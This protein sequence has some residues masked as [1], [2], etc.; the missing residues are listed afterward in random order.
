[1]IREPLRALVGRALKELARRRPGSAISE[2]GEAGDPTELAKV[3]DLAAIRRAREPREMSFDER[4][5]F[6]LQAGIAGYLER[7]AGLE[8]PGPHKVVIDAPFLRAHGNGLAAVI[9][10]AM[11]LSLAAES[12]LR[13]FVQLPEPSREEA[14]EAPVELR[15]EIDL[16]SILRSTLGLGSDRSSER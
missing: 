14:A 8:G 11:A 15:L 6:T 10:Q 1:M 12:P 5:R 9:F 2:M 7:C 13:A 3:I 16:K 4:F